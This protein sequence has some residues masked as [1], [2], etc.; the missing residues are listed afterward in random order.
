[1]E[2]SKDLQNKIDITLKEFE[3]AQE[4]LLASLEANQ[5]ISYSVASEKIISP[6]NKIAGE[7]IGKLAVEIVLGLGLTLEEQEKVLKTFETA[8]ENYKQISE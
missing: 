7:L 6:M 8:I 2:I 4:T 5:I 1:M 3:N